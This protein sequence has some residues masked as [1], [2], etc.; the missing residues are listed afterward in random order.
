MAY[1]D[2]LV[3]LDRD[4]RSRMS[5]VL[6]ATLAERFGAHLIGLYA[7]RSL[8]REINEK[9]CSEAETT[10]IIFE[11]IAGRQSISAEW[12]TA[13]GN[14]P[15]EVAVHGRYADLTILGQHDPD[16]EWSP[17]LR[18]PPGRGRIGGRSAGA[19]CPLRRHL[20]ADRPAGSGRLGCKS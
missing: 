17:G 5:I 4:E 6:A 10:R 7:L 20:R 15:D 8:D 11:E 3:V 18:P 2:L 12:R 19:R 13:S 14:L 9:I 1:K 16:Y